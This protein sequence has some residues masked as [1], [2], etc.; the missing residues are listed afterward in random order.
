MVVHVL[1]HAGMLKEFRIPFTDD[2]HF[3]PRVNR[4][5]PGVQFVSPD[6][7]SIAKLLSAF[8]SA[9]EMVSIKCTPTG[10]D[11]LKDNIVE[12]RTYMMQDGMLTS[13]G[14]LPGKIRDSFV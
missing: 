1:T 11:R 4:D 12:L 10:Q 14:F 13:Y 3:S 7:S 5:V 8:H 6:P 2:Q 9:S